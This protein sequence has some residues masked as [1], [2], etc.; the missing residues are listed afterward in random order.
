V[1]GEQNPLRGHSEL[2]IDY[3]KQLASLDFGS[4]QSSL[5][6]PL[7]LALVP[8]DVL[9]SSCVPLLPGNADSAHGM[10]KRTLC[11][12]ARAAQHTAATRAEVLSDLNHL[13]QSVACGPETPSTKF[14]EWNVAIGAARRFPVQSDQVKLLDPMAKKGRSDQ[15]NNLLLNVKP[16]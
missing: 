13:A 12:H 2:F 1:N 3:R 9:H 16:C 5:S 4:L 8:S 10:S 6:R 7:R 15:L 14:S 11:S